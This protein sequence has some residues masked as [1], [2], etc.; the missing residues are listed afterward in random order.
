[1]YVTF[2]SGGLPVSLLKVKKKVTHPRVDA[3][4]A[5]AIRIFELEGERKYPGAEKAP[6]EFWTNQSIEGYTPEMLE[7]QGMF[8][9]GMGGGRYDEHMSSRDGECATSL[10]LRDLGLLRDPRYGRLL[11]YALRANNTLGGSPWEL[12]PMMKVAHDQRPHEPFVV[13]EAAWTFIDG[14]IC[15]QGDYLSTPQRRG[16]NFCA[17]IPLPSKTGSR[18]KSSRRLLTTEPSGNGLEK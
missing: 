16:P 11:D 13:L 15:A 18:R 3:D 8:L 9:F 5:I 10:V 2:N 7:K 12:N 14:L 4:E 6:V 1:L 17:G